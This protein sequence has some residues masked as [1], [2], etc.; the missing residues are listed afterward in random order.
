MNLLG[1]F[2]RRDLAIARSYRAPFVFDFVFGF[3]QLSV[4]YFL[5]RTFEDIP[6]DQLDG[7][8]DYFAFA[9]VGIVIALVIEASI[10]GVAE[11]VREGQLTGSL[12]ALLSQPVGPFQLCVGFVS[13][14]AAFAVLRGLIY[15]FIAALFLGLQL[16]EADWVGLLII[17]I[18]SIGAIASIGVLTGAALMRFKRGE[19][20]AG[21]LV[22]A[23]TIVS[24]VGVSNQRAS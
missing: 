13:F 2:I 12:E 19:A 8:P 3:L 16:G 4:F 11:R 22:F 9:A 5:S 7:A 1:A 18:T 20:L 10:Q 6:S 17:L 21:A 23:M 14:P 15:L 24:G